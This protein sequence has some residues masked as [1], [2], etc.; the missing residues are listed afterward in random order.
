[1]A[2]IGIDYGTSNSEVVFFDGKDHQFVKL[3]PLNKD[4]N[5]IR[6][7]I[8]IYFEDDLPTPPSDMIE[9]KVSQIKRSITEQIEKAKQG[10]YDSR[11]PKEQNIFSARIDELRGQFHDKPGLQRKAI[12]L[13]LKNMTVQDLSLNQLVAHGK[14]AFGEEGFKRFLAHPNK[15]RLIYSPKNFL[16]ASLDETQRSAFVGMIGK[17]LAYFKNNAET[18]L[19]APVTEAVIGRPV[20]FHG[21]RGDE[22]NTQAISIMTKAAEFAGFEKVSFL[23]EPIAAAYKIERTLNKKT[24]A[25]VVDIG[26]G[27]TDICC[28]TLSPEKYNNIDRQQ[29]VLSVTGTR[30]GGMECD[31]SLVL[32]A[33][34]PS[35]GMGLKTFNGLPVPPTY[36]SDMCA[37]DD[38]P[39]LTRFFHEDYGL[40]IAQTMSIVE[41]SS[42]LERLL[43]VQEEKLSARLVNSSRLAKELLSSQDEIVLP[44]NYIEKDF[45][46]SISKTEL[47]ES[48]KSWLKRVKKLITDCLD[49]TSHKP[50][51]LF[52]TGGMSL[53]PIV[54]DEIQKNWLPELPVVEGDAFNSVC[55]GLAIR[56]FNLTNS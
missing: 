38:I 6:S 21:T 29:D 32:K 28:I 1:M 5:K 18:Q 35:M 55:E 43:T 12:Q 52:I 34:A 46:V 15:G 20:R 44:L 31:K 10:Y 22:G 4:S 42:S 51:I 39:K 53:S 47:N 37:V 19:K 13:L 30:L 11:D 40:D 3:D 33:I 49:N 54:I 9:A 36:F 41:N 24:N 26:G 25:L 27:T 48:M 14:F 45:Q 50:D 56:A 16:G 17:Q 2:A 23:E 8:F 7:S